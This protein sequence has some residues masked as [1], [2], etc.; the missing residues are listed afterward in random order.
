[1]TTTTERSAR[2]VPTSAV[3]AT[4]CLCGTVVALQ[5]TL[6]V[7]SLPDFPELLGI[8]CGQRVVAG[9]LSLALTS[10]LLALSKGGR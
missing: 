8:P 6:V 1:V 9:L 3:T 5:Q 10:L 2:A 7:P 4:L